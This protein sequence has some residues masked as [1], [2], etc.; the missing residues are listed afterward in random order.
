M[1]NKNVFLNKSK[2][3]KKFGILKTCFTWFHEKIQISVNLV[4][5]KIQKNFPPIIETLEILV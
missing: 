3:E 1:T 4:F 5:F 2:I